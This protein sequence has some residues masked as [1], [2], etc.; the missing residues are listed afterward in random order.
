MGIW[1]EDQEGSRLIT[2][3]QWK[4]LG[5]QSPPA[6]GVKAFGVAFSQTGARVA[7]AGAMKHANGVH[8]ELVGAHS[9]SMGAGVASLADW[10]AERWQ[11][12]ATIVISGRSGAGV[13]HEALRARGVP[14]RVLHVAS[15]ADYLTSCSMLANDATE[16][17]PRLTHLA[18]E[19][20]VALDASIAICDKKSRGAGGAWGWVATTPDGDETPTEAVSLALWGVK[21]TKRKPGRT[22]RVV[23]T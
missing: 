16:T 20:Q 3:D 8:V 5:I 11:S 18:T 10:L 9:G 6:D 22:T 4:A 12:T 7:V 15:T 2:A 21:T 17:R 13:L 19:G 23:V 14:E 1:D